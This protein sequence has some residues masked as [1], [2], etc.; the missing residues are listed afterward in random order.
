M[1]PSVSPYNKE[2]PVENAVRW[3]LFHRDRYIQV[4]ALVTNYS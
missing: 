1:M 2:S 3:Q 4:A